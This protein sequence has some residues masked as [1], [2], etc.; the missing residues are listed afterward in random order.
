MGRLHP[1]C[2]PSRN[3]PKLRPIRIKGIDREK[4]E[5]WSQTDLQTKCSR[6]DWVTEEGYDPA[7]GR[8]EKTSEPVL[9]TLLL[10]DTGVGAQSITP[11]YKPPNT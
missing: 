9:E 7:Q 8:G 3:D 6:P 11:K 5:D 1:L 10:H 4:P 2:W